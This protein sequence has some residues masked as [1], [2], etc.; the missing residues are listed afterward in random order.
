M[1]LSIEDSDDDDGNHQENHFE[2]TKS[3]T[4]NKR[5]YSFDESDV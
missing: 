2:R 1:I 5:Y 4:S 3:V